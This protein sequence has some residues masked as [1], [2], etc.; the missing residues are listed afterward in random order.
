MSKK[1]RPN[2]KS[3]IPQPPTVQESEMKRLLSLLGEQYSVAGLAQKS[4]L[5]SSFWAWF[6]QIRFEPQL[7]IP[8]PRFL[9][10]R[11]SSHQ[12]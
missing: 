11:E 4:Y 7:R 6:S 9:S 8:V 3:D 1:R 5:L 12:P 10:H 2:R